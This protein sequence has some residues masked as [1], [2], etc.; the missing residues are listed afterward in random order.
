[1]AFAI[2]PAKATVAAEAA[3][4]GVRDYLIATLAPAMGGSLQ[5]SNDA[6]G[7]IVLKLDPSLPLSDEGYRLTCTSNGVT[8]TGRTPAGVFYGVQTLRQLLPATAFGSKAIENVH[9]AVPLVQI[10]DDPR[11]PWRG[12]HLDVARHFF[13][14]EEV[15]NYLDLMAM[16]KLNTFHWHLVD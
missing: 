4:A 7:A 12:L 14:K 2:D 16:H 15:K 13:N 9:W 1:K 10:E 3:L 8:I 5:I 11:F 6:S